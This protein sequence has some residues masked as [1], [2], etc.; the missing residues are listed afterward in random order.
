M[1]FGYE[2]DGGLGDRLIAAVL[3]GDKTATSS[4]VVSYLAGDPLPRV[5]QRSELVDHSGHRHG[6][7]ETTRVRVIPLNEVGDDVARDEGEGFADAAEWRRA[8]E[9]FWGAVAGM[10]RAEAGD[11]TW[12]LRDS[13]PV[14]VEWFRLLADRGRPAG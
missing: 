13:E 2:G 9:E 14:V 7:V 5:G 4:L 12:E 8:H 10:I 3:C 1:S 6:V 11:A